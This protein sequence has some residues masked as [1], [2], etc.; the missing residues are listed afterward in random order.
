MDLEYSK[1]LSVVG[2]EYIPSFLW[3]HLSRFGTFR[4][5]PHHKDFCA[6]TLF[7]KIP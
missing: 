7:L 6:S 3:T 4:G 5:H 1:S 2:P